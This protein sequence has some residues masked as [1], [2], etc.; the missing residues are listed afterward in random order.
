LVINNK[1]GQTETRNHYLPFNA[2][3]SAGI[4]RNNSGFFFYFNE[5]TMMGLHN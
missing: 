1:A 2:L 4:A 3:F 5:Q